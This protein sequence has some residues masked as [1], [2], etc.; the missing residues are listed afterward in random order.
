[1]E[2]RLFFVGIILAASGLISPPFALLGGLVY[3]L[4]LTHPYHTESKSLSKFLLQASVVGLGFGMNLQQVLKAGKSGFLYTLCGIAFALS[5]G[6]ILGKV[7]SVQSNSSY[8]ISVGTA[9]CGGSAIADG[10]SD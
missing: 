10:R 7:L 4:L 3:G 1:M 8:L 6:W 9:I 5:L 2:K